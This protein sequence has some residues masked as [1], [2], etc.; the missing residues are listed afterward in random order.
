MRTSVALFS[1]LVIVVFGSIAVWRALERQTSHTTAATAA[2]AADGSVV[3]RPTSEPEN[4]GA[5]RRL[6]V[7]GEASRENDA[8]NDVRASDGADDD[9]SATDD[10]GRVSLSRPLMEFGDVSA[11][12]R[13]HRLNPKSVAPTE[14][15][16]S[17][18]SELL[19]ALNRE[20]RTLFFDMTDLVDLCAQQK[21][22]DGHV[23]TFPLG[24]RTP[25]NAAG[26][27]GVVVR[28]AGIDHQSVAIVRE[29]EFADLDVNLAK[30]RELWSR[31]AAEIGSILETN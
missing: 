25:R 20:A 26:P 19:T 11:V 4:S 10:G 8:A 29:G 27:D 5:S 9:S 31:G 23:Q 7:A 2:T 1:A 12:L 18:L 16:L 21:V 22:T 6:A 17:Q 15:Q 3:T 30:Q 24:E 13:D 28:L 14:R